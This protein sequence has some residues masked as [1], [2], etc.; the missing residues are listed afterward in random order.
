MVQPYMCF[1][2]MHIQAKGGQLRAHSHY[3][4]M[5]EERSPHFTMFRLCFLNED[6]LALEVVES[7]CV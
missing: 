4:C 5:N 6:R 7:H 3:L 2:V 1:S